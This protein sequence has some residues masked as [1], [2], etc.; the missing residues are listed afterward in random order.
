MLVIP[1]QTEKDEIVEEEGLAIE[2]EENNYEIDFCEKR[3]RFE[4]NNV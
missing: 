3:I 2:K 1:I 4:I